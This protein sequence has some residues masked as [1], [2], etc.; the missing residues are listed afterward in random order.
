MSFALIANPQAG[1]GRA[2]VR[3]R[4]LL[5]E[6][7]RKNVATHLLETRSA[8][9]A[10][11][12]AGKVLES[13][14]CETLG[15]LGGDG[16]LSEVCQAYVDA[17]G[18][19]IEGPA[20]CLFPSGTGG[21]TARGLSIPNSLV[22]GVDRLLNGTRKRIDLGWLALRA[23]SGS[24]TSRTFV[25]I[26]SVGLTATVALTINNGPKWL[27]GGP[28]YFLGAL[29]GAI[30]YRNLPVRIEVDGVEWHRGPVTLAA[31]A[32]GRFF[33]G[34]MKIAPEA[35]P[36]SGLLELV[37]LGDLSRLKLISNLPKVYSGQHMDL[38]EVSRV[39]GRR[40]R[41]EYVRNENASDGAIE[42]DGETPGRLP[43]EAKIL[44]GAL[45]MLLPGP[46]LPSAKK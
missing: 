39:Q 20:I 24:V 29:A 9:H 5:R 2:A 45:Q 19:A 36:S 38:P 27:G 30:S 18:E 37:C 6:L 16:T 11:E 35:D 4:A 8:G 12:L 21:D 26:A 3:L 22:E 23:E 13:G 44:P 10:T 43:L 46:Q 15:V 31:I 42:A 33:G 28:A 7:E 1:G 40:I 34:G 14:A 41:I 25:N 17:T 32:N